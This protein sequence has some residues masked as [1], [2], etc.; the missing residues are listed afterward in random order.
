MS[1]SPPVFQKAGIFLSKNRR[2]VVSSREARLMG[3]RRYLQEKIAQIGSFFERRAT[4]GRA[5]EKNCQNER[6]LLQIWYA[7]YDSNVRPS[8]PQAD[9]LSNW[10]TGTYVDST[11]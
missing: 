4:Y 8:A 3:K 2:L 11:Y 9:A 10:A 7:R 1:L 6:F 5:S